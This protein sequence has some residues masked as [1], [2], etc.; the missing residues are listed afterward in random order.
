MNFMQ[1]KVILLGSHFFCLQVLPVSTF[2]L[3]TISATCFLNLWIL[4]GRKPYGL[5]HHLQTISALSSLCTGLNW[6]VLCWYILY[7]AVGQLQLKTLF[8]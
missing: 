8:S 5:V 3:L 4:L 2:F 1:L 6:T 7:A